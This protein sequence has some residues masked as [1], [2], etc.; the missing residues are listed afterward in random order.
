MYG[1]VGGAV[2]TNNSHNETQTFLCGFQHSACKVCITG[3]VIKMANRT[4]SSERKNYSC[5]YASLLSL[6]SVFLA[7]CSRERITAGLGNGDLMLFMQIKFQ[8][9]HSFPS[10]Y[11]EDGKRSWKAKGQKQRGKV[12]PGSALSKYFYRIGAELCEG[13]LLSCIHSSWAECL[14]TLLTDA[15]LT[16]SDNKKIHIITLHQP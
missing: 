11:P 6:L 1:F 10:Q 9:C 3:T 14:V 16:S 5:T 8:D 2:I 12:E 13:Q 7:E 4:R 15:A